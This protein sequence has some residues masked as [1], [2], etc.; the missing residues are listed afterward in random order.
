MAIIFKVGTA[1]FVQWPNIVKCKF[2]HCLE[3]SSGHSHGWD[4]CNTWERKQA[5]LYIAKNLL[6]AR[7]VLRWFSHTDSIFYANKQAENIAFCYSLI[8]EKNFED[9]SFVEVICLLYLN[10]CLGYWQNYFLCCVGLSKLCDSK[11]VYLFICLFIFETEF[12][13]TAQAPLHL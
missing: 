13:Y 8:F 3:T 4:I 6:K 1:V 10:Q 7:D 9:K 2:L 12:H 5:N 11:M